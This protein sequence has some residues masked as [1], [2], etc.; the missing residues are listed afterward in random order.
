[1]SHSAVNV[2]T[3]I[4]SC[5]NICKFHYLHKENEQARLVRLVSGFVVRKP[6]GRGH[7]SS[8]GGIQLLVRI[9]PK[10]WVLVFVRGGH[11]A[12][13]VRGDALH[14]NNNENG[15]GETSCGF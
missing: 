2:T 11:A 3:V 8:R 5:Q 6:G 4:D 9:P 14:M 7:W 1:V 10:A 12:S 13:R 15:T